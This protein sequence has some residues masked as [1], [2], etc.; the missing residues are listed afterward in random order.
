MLE[1]MPRR[2]RCLP[3]A[4]PGARVARP[5]AH[6]RRRCRVSAP[7]LRLWSPPS[8]P[9]EPRPPRPGRRPRSFRPRPEALED[10]TV[11]STIAVWSGDDSLTERGTLRYAVAQ[12]NAT[13]GEDTILL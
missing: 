10:R 8:H 7:S 2:S 4:K 9:A 3:R 13:P 1:V 11:L 6:N 5:L 12:A